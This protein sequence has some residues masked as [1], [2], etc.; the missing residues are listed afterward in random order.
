MA[1]L[2]QRMLGAAK[3]DSATY[4]EVES[5]ATATPQAMLV[6]VLAN[7]AAGIGV[8]RELGFGGLVVA[9]LISLVGWLVWAFVAYFVGTRLLPGARTQADIGQLLRTIGFSA[10]P[11]LIRV[12][13]IVPGLDWLVSLV[14]ALWMVAAMVVA[15]RQA[16][17]YDTT[18]RAV[19]VC[20]IGFAINVVVLIVLAKIMGVSAGIAEP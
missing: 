19:A 18:G 2:T 16:L 6:V 15:V 10:T 1:S 3:L 11:G 20:A 13:G 14:A 8:A 17:D 7:L 12:L 4:E 5:D 9:T